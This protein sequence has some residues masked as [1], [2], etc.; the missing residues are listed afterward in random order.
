MLEINLQSPVPI[1]DQIK[2]GLRGLVSKGILKPG[3]KAPSVRALAM[4]LRV[5]P[6]TVARALRELTQEGFLEAARGEASCI[7]PQ[8]PRLARG[9]VAAAEKQF[10]EAAELALNNGLTKQELSAIIKELPIGDK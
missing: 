2:G 4:E 1:Y 9:G 5:N 3:D 6:N 7:S 8:A 10:R